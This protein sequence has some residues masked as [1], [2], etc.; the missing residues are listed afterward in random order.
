MSATVG[1]KEKGWLEF[2]YRATAEPIRFPV[3]TV[4]GAKDGPVLAV[5]GGTHGSEFAGIEAAI[6]LYNEVD[7]AQLK[8]TLKVCMIYNLPAFL[9]NLGFV[10]PHDGKNPLSTFPGS[11]I[12]TFGEAMAYY[13]DQEFLSKADYYVEMHGGDIPEALTPFIL[14]STTGDAETDARIEGLAHAYNV[15]LIVK[16]PVNDPADPP[17]GGFGVMCTR[18]KPAILAES[19]QQ[20]ILKMDEVHTHLLGA[21]NVLIHLGMLPG[22]VVNT[23]KRTFLDN[24]TAVRSEHVAMWYPDVVLSQEIAKGQ[25][26]GHLRDYWGQPV[27][28]VTAPGD[29]IVTAIRTSP[30]TRVG[31]VLV[32]YGHIAGREA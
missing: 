28:E 5:S 29:G 23:V 31:N 6:Q 32:E 30:A 7:P 27:A 17:G 15:P 1:S 24:Y 3:G 14:S 16:Y 9:N 2:K 22:Q 25:V 20:G 26:I 4:H 18:G 19:G 8:G 12:G 11:P 10:V 21:R 13:F